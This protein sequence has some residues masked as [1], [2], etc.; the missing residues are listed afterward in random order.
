MPEAE[1]TTPPQF[2][3]SVALFDRDGRLL[4]W[5]AGFESEFGAGPDEIV[6]GVL[7]ED[8]LA[9][10]FRRDGIARAAKTDDGAPVAPSL[11]DP[12]D[13]GGSGPDYAPRYEDDLGRTVRVQYAF[14]PSGGMFRT[15]LPVAVEK[16][17]HEAFV[18]A[19]EQWLT[20]GDPD[21]TANYTMNMRPN[22]GLECEYYPPEA[23][24]VFGFPENVELNTALILSRMV[25]SSEETERNRNLFESMRQMHMPISFDVRVRGSDDRLRWV[26][27]N[28]VPAPQPDGSIQLAVQLRD[29]TRE[30]LAEDQLELMRSVVTSVTD[31][32]WVL[33][34]APNE[35]TTTL[36]VNPAFERATGW[37]A[38]KMVGKLV[39]PEIAGE[40]APWATLVAMGE[41]NDGA[42]IEI[43]ATNP[44]GGRYW[45]EMSATT[46]DRSSDG[47]RRWVLISRNID[48]RRRDQEELLKAK[49]AAE[50]ANRAKSEFLANMS[51]EIRT[52]MN[53]LLGMTSLLLETAL[54][55]Q[56]EHYTRTVEQ[57]GEAL[58]TI[59]ND[60]LDISKLEAGK[61]ELEIIDFD[62]VDMIENAA[63]LISP[64]AAEKGVDVAIDIDPAAEVIFRGDANRLRQI[65]LNLVGNS[66]KFTEQGHVSLHVSVLGEPADA[67]APRTLRFAVTD[68]GIGM[69]EDA[70]QRL[71]Q[72]FSQADSSITRR[73]GGTGLGLAIC[74]QLVDLMCGRIGVDSAPG[75]GSTF[76]FEVPLCVS[77]SPFVRP[78]PGRLPQLGAMRVL[79]VDDI[80]LNLEIVARQLKGLG[81]D[82]VTTM[83][84][85]KDAVAEVRRAWQSGQ[86]YD[87]I[88]LDQMMPDLSGDSLAAELRA[89]PEFSDVG[90]I[91]VS[92]S[93]SSGER[94]GQANLFD[95]VLDKP[96]R[97]G[98]LLGGLTTLF[99]DV[100]ETAPEGRVEEQPLEQPAEQSV[101]DGCFETESQGLRV[102][103]AEDHKINQQ[104]AL[105][106]LA[107]GGHVA[108]LVENGRQA[109]E[110]VQASHYDVILM[111]IHM[112]ECDGI[113]ATRLIRAMAAPKC[114]IPIIALTADAMSGSRDEYVAAGMDDYLSKPVKA[115]ELLSKL[116]QLGV[117]RAETHEERIAIKA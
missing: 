46:L 104:F 3:E 94:A 95:V 40:N 106:V 98:D 31:S 29:V 97:R 116:A 5:S 7:F 22:G 47:S 37:S 70:R 51:H 87:V 117:Y 69:D 21:R 11:T 41:R 65:V 91:L 66:I 71:F 78:D 114:D 14:T 58:M 107:A 57:S 62:V 100:L 80:A 73:Y 63:T 93:G 33:H 84:Q 111:D 59:I 34:T 85:P 45:M 44:S 56:Q 86:P 113:E 28:L 48:D 52:P 103:L 19:E 9:E 12:R 79:V 16:A 1:L 99:N 2:D 8:L 83:T 26:H 92:S 72:K 43:C 25:Q 18:V 61:V 90:M 75:Q 24:S 89:I 96:L 101:D 27:H 13:A 115:A 67:S 74:K 81:L 23:A 36:Y 109:V 105:A 32:I 35:T 68:T 49:D 77:D 39:S 10:A 6:V 112:P 64:R 54:T 55:D 102:L 30:K 42:S 15:A 50:A 110:A 76:W 38:G 82:Q 4:E 20:D 17:T 108:D 53:G 88:I 60:I